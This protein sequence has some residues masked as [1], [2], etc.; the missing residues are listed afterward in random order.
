MAF[1]LLVHIARKGREPVLRIFLKQ[2]LTVATFLA[3]LLVVLFSTNVFAAPSDA[4]DDYGAI[5]YSPG[6]NQTFP[7]LAPVL[8]DAENGAQNACFAAGAGDCQVQVWVRYGY[9][10]VASY[11]TRGYTYIYAFGSGYGTTPDEASSSAI[12]MCQQ[13]NSENP[14]GCNIV[15]G[16]YYTPLPHNSPTEGQVVWFY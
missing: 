8:S 16:V 11:D 3:L 15:G 2:R 1:I 10:A 6:L 13:H 7:G 14:S 5:S 4:S 12:Q 9:A